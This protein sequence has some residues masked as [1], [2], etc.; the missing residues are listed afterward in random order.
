VELPN[1]QK[2]DL[3]WHSLSQIPGW[4]EKLEARGCRV[5]L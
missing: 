5:L 2:L 4:L 3:R 1:L